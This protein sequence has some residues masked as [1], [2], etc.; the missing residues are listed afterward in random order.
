[1]SLLLRLALVAVVAALQG[2]SEGTVPIDP[3][4]LGTLTLSPAKLDFGTVTVGE[5]KSLSAVASGA[6]ITAVRG[7]PFDDAFAFRLVTG[8][9]GTTIAVTYTPVAERSSVGAL[10]VKV[11][12]VT[13]ATLVLEGRGSEPRLSA[14]PQ[15]LDFGTVLVGQQRALALTLT[16]AAVPSAVSVAMENIGPC[17]SLG[18]T[19]FCVEGPVDLSAGF[20]LA[21]AE[22]VALEVRYAPTQ[23]SVRDRA[24]LSFRPCPGCGL[25]SVQI[26]GSAGAGDIACAPT[27]LSFGEVAPGACATER[28]TCT[29]GGAAAR[30]VVNARTD[31]DFEVRGAT[32]P[33]RVEPGA[34]VPVEVALCPR[35]P[36]VQRGLLVIDTDAASA[37]A[38]RWTVALTGGQDGAPSIVVD[39]SL[40]FPPTSLIA[41][42]R[43]GVTIRNAGTAP[44]ELSG[45]SL[46]SGVNSAF[47]LSSAQAEVIAPGGSV[48][49]MV[50]FQPRVVGVVRD[51]LF[52]RS[53]DPAQGEAVV[54]LSGEGVDVP[55]CVHQLAP[56]PLDFGAVERGRV[57]RRGIEVRNVGTGDCLL[58]GVWQRPGSPELALHG[59]QRHARIAPGAAAVIE[60]DFAPVGLQASQGR[61][62]V[63]LSDP[64]QPYNDVSITGLGVDA[65]LL[66]GPRELDLGTASAMCG[67]LDREVRLHAAGDDTLVV[68]AVS[69]QDG[70]RSFEVQVPGLPIT[71]APSETASL[72][73]GLSATIVSPRAGSL[74]LTGTQAGVPMTWYVGVRGEVSASRRQVDTFEQRAAGSPVDVLL[75]LDNSGGMGE[76]LRAVEAGVDALVREA[77]ASGVDYRIGITTTDIDTDI[78]RFL[79]ISVAPMTRVV[80]AASAPTPAAALR[81]NMSSTFSES[82]SAQECGLG[83]TVMA[84]SSPLIFEHNA[85]FLRREAALAVIALSDE[86]DYSEGTPALY[87][88]FVRSSKSAY[89]APTS[90]TAIVGD[91]GTGCNGA[92]GVASAADDYIEVARRTGGQFES[93]CTL[94]GA[95]PDMMGRIAGRVFGPRLRYELRSAPVIRTI[96]VRVDGVAVPEMGANGQ[97]QWRYD[98]STRAVVL[99]PFQVPPPGAQIEISYEPECGA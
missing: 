67:A 24:T 7:E 50:Q 58:T 32:L 69:F 83:A 99:S 30:S 21:P 96:E 55:P 82:G 75:I 2:C 43:R 65:T 78:G 59:G 81:A 71:L 14:R 93:I 36:G 62:E 5:V 94:P 85:G 86:E 89:G 88:D 19:P 15:P 39:A 97:V 35:A 20:P 74:R 45:Y 28:V 92:G 73:V 10:L 25:V 77:E 1:M 29:N 11:D 40:E 4:E 68:N 23:A 95:G 41:P 84:L 48:E 87:A 47:A 26:E 52:L 8:P 18:A 16:N 61:L 53:N 90:F 49:V 57:V 34:S 80:T 70:D 56:S 17:G 6:T 63:D 38:R 91:A 54:A 37:E 33:M 98:A 3:G 42:S 12:G 22:V 44:L 76:E 66:I 60:V 51:A 9:E 31:G 46:E 72:E 13:R 79:P 27:A 64:R